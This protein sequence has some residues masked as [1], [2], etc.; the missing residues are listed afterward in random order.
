MKFYLTKIQKLIKKNIEFFLLLML[1]IFASI[2]TQI[3]NLNK[4][5]TIINFVNLTENIYF[6]KSLEHIFN[7]LKPK[8]QTINHKITKGE[9]FNSILKKYDISDKEIKKINTALVKIQNSSKL[10][11]NQNIKFTIDQSIDHDKWCRS[12]NC[13]PMGI[14]IATGMTYFIFGKA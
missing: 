13:T 4:E 14:G 9:N 8:Y 10:K 1:I 12:I 5:K 11:V 2:S 3:Y 7:N 6:Q